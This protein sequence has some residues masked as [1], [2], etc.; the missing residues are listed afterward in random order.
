MNTNNVIETIGSIT[1]MEHLCASSGGH[2]VNTLVL[3]NTNPFPGVANKRD[4]QNMS[5]YFIVL[6]YRYAPEKISRIN[7]KLH[8]KLNL[9]RFPSY[10]EIISQGSV[11]P[12]I[13]L[14]GI[15]ESQLAD[16]QLFLQKN[17]LKFASFK[18]FDKTCRIKIFKSFKL[19]EIAEDLYRDLSDGEKVYLHINETLNW[20]RF[21]FITRKIKSSIENTDFDAALGVIYRFEG[22]Q[23]VIRLYDHN[24]NLDR[25][26]MLKKMYVT[27]IKKE[28][29]IQAF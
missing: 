9:S 5:S 2:L 23:N 11:L 19:V 12:C 18:P 20:K 1:K 16:I 22:P 27:E 15:V 3:T 24:K 14:K 10:G 21:D 4:E 26:L 7:L 29:N 8:K 25:A 17:D 28:I 13:R 6:R